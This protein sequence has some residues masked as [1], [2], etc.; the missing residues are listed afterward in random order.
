[1]AK[2][3][4][5]GQMEKSEFNRQFFYYLCDPQIILVPEGQIAVPNVFVFCLENYMR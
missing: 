3:K 4:K 2:N 5:N 1:V